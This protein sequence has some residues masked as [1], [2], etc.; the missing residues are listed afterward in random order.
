MSKPQFVLEEVLEVYLGRLAGPRNDRGKTFD[1][2]ADLNTGI[3][4]GLKAARGEILKEKADDKYCIVDYPNKTVPF[5]EGLKRH[6]K[7]VKDMTCNCL[8]C[9]NLNKEPK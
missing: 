1:A 3:L 9:R 7:A 8:F 6:F 5:K 4:I 2:I